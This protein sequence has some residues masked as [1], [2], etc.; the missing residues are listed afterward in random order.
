MQGDTGKGRKKDGKKQDEETGETGGQGGREPKRAGG[1]DP[2]GQEEEE[3]GQ[4]CTE[5]QTW[6]EGGAVLRQQDKPQ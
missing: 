1:Q 2:W 3:K 4:Q 5:T 6:G